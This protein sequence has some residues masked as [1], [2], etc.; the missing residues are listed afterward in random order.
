MAVSSGLSVIGSILT[1]IA[2]F[3][4]PP[5]TALSDDSAAPEDERR[6]LRSPDPRYS[7]AVINESVYSSRVFPRDISSIVYPLILYKYSLIAYFT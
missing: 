5:S 3:Y 6:L 7:S 1:L 4:F 2:F